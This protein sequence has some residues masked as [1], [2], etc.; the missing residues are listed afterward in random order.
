[1]ID[2]CFSPI[3]PKKNSEETV[4]QME[5]DLRNNRL[6]A[7]PDLDFQLEIIKAT[8]NKAYKPTTC[9]RW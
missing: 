7:K 8:P 4:K 6:T 2:N 5:D 3:K 9:R 1:M